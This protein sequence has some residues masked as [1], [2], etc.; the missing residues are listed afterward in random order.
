MKTVI[1]SLLV[2]LY[3]VLAIF[4][5]CKRE[6]SCENCFVNNKPPKA[7]AG[8]DQKIVLPLDSVLLDGT[9]S[10]DPDGTITSYKWT[11]ISGPGSFIYGNPNQIKTIIRNLKA[12]F[13]KIELTVSDDGGLQ[14]RDTTQIT[15]DSANTSNHAP[16]ANAGADQT[17]VLPINTIMLDG[18]SSTDPDNNITSYTW[19]K[20]NGPSSYTL[21][22]VNAAQT[23]AT[24]LAEGVYQFE[25]KV[26][27]AGGLFS[28]DTVE[29]KVVSSLS[30]CNTGNR[31]IV[32][33]NLAQVGKLSEP[34]AGVAVGAAGNK[35]VFGGGVGYNN[36]SSGAD[37][38]DI[39]TRTW[40]TAKLSVARYDMAVVTSGNKIFFAG[41]YNT[42]GTTFADYYRNVDIYDA[43][44]NTW[45]VAMLSSERSGIAAAAV[46][47]KVFFAGG[48]A[49]L[50]AG[51][52]TVVDIYDLTTN[53]WSIANLSEGRK[54]VSA[55]TVAN[56][57][58]FAGGFNQWISSPNS[59]DLLPSKKIDIY[60]NA[61]NAWSTSALVDAR[62]DMAG[63]A[64]G[65]KIFWAGGYAGNG[66]IL[67]KV[68]IRDINSQSNSFDCLFQ[69]NHVFNAVLKDTK[70]VFSVGPTGYL[71][72]DLNKFN[73]Y[74][75]AT[76]T[77]SIGE[78][79]VN[80]Y[81]ASFIS[82][83]NKIY[84][85]GGTNTNTNLFDEVWMID[86]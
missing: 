39:V 42:D 2:F 56:K 33:V 52:S 77:W 84:F 67:S 79:T 28:K 82:V 18:R 22:N 7:N 46:G 55:T 58:Y 38:F 59:A 74:D 73:I 15:V 69:P 61:T 1:R 4:S 21:S 64:V 76:N 34:K 60:D 45:T 71:S 47:N 51:F 43:S 6:H 78:M 14:S 57:I 25:L 8:A 32:H 65:N 49:N 40:S 81:A 41:G 48:A 35:I 13:Y 36:G 75:M 17:I 54:D 29:V 12:G 5:S 85:A 80:R 72:G 37:I 83:N 9:A 30:S 10:S 24:N 27:D 63:L 23:T 62:G 66:N 68:E 26:V 16:V 19:T 3:T 86:F 11:T 31:P 50:N 70:I 53:T 44:T 20:I